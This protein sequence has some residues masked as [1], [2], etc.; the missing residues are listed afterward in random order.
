MST[1]TKRGRYWYYNRNQLRRSLRVTDK[2]T[3]ERIRAKWDND[4][5]LK[6]AGITVINE[7]LLDDMI[8]DW[9]RFTHKPPAWYDRI[10]ISIKHFQAYAGNLVVSDID[11]KLINEFIAKRSEIVAPN[12]IKIDLNALRQLFSYAEDNSYIDRNPVL[13]ANKPKYKIQKPR[14]PLPKRILQGIFDLAAS[15]DRIYW[16]VCYYTGLSPSDAGTLQPHVIKDGIIHTARI[17]TGTPATIPLHPVLL[18]LGDKIYN[19]MPLKSA[20]DDSNRRFVVLC[21]KRGIKAVIYS[22]RHSFVSHLFDMGLSLEDIKVLTGHTSSS[23]T[24]AY[25]KAQIDIIRKYIFQL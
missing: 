18:D 16:M 11:V 17:K 22:L 7:I 8:R 14:S 1:L 15:R 25:T 5:A 21:K 19:C 20:R 4:Y 13:K 2:A 24:A 12:T 10:S 9:Y 6:R 23:T 3:A